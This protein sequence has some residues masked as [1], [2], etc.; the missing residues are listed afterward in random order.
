MNF[1][2]S[3]IG[4]E[5]SASHKKN[6]LADCSLYA[7]LNRKPLAALFVL[8]DADVLVPGCKLL[9]DFKCLVVTSIF[10]NEDF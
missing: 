9:R 1:A 5:R 7:M 3:S 2:I 8:Q 10:D 4:I 6:V